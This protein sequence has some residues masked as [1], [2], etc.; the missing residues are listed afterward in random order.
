MRDD[1]HV[2]EAR[3]REDLQRLNPDARA[4]VAVV[5]RSNCGKSSLVNALLGDAH[6]RASKTPGRTRAAQLFGFGG[7]VLVDLP[8]YGYASGP[9][10]ELDGLADVIRACVL[11]RAPEDPL[12]LV[13]A[14][15]DARRVVERGLMDSDAS[16]IG[17]LVFARVPFDVV[18]TKADA[19]NRTETDS[20]RGALAR[21][22]AARALLRGPASLT[23]LTSARKGTG[24]GE[25]K[26]RL[27]RVGAGTSASASAPRVSP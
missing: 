7:A 6:A 17:A 16:M 24:V 20:V 4:E 26:S 14:L 21:E 23:F 19:L 5:G 27:K 2:G 18:L 13:L 12:K 15:V 11:D 9:A 25:L 10:R 1:L 3:T 22:L 8:G